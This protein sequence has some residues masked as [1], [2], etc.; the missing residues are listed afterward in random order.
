MIA[1]EKERLLDLARE[2]ARIMKET[3]GTRM[4]SDR[5]E[6]RLKELEGVKR[7]RPGTS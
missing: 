3:R 5:L 7:R 4:R 2:L 1:R 6:G